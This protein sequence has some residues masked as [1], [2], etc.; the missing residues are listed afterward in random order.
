MAFKC[1]LPK[2]RVP[3]FRFSSHGVLDN[4][5]DVSGRGIHVQGGDKDTQRRWVDILAE[6]RGPGKF[7]EVL[8]FP[9]LPDHVS[10][11]FG[12]RV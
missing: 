11:E 2:I 10:Q 9:Q 6:S 3:S 1:S 8:L 12:P 5:P 4:K 7:D